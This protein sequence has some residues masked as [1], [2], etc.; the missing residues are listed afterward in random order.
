MYRNEARGSHAGGPGSGRR[1]Q[2][3]VEEV[4]WM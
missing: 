3:A 1:F 2:V 4:P